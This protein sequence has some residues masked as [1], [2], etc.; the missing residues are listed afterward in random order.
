MPP[1][2]TRT[3]S[4]GETP[5]VPQIHVSPGEE[6]SG[7]GP[8]S[9]QGLRPR[10]RT[11]RNA[12]RPPSNSHGDWPFLRRP[13]SVPEVPV[14]KNSRRSRRISRGGVLHRK[15]ERN[16][17]VVPPFQEPPDV[18]VH[19]R[20][21]CFP[22]TALTFKPRIDSHHVC[23]ERIAG[24][25]RRISGGGALHR[26]GEKKSRVVRPFQESPRCVS[27]FKR[28]LFSLHCLDVQAEDRLP[29]RVHVGQPCGNASWES[30]VGK[31]RGKTIDP[32]LHAADCVTLLLPLW[33]KAHSIR[34]LTPLGRLQKYPKIHVSTGEESS[35]SGPESTQ[36]LR[37][38][39]RRE[40]NPERPPRNSHGDWPF[41][42]PPDRVPDVPVVSR[43]HLPQL[44]KIQEVLPSRR[45]EDHFR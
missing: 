41:L 45:D 35:G 6:S 21:T 7:S 4:P 23:T 32:L 43:E 19:S 12:E 37:P 16:S 5:E 22:C 18:S 8:D 36:G 14:G 11:E 2:E 39:H 17:R 38:R 27:P 31:T 44:E 29:Q 25:S 1:C 34:G 15:G 13:E 10:H 9:T 40:R 30:L 42:R 33:R 24:R 26:K 20:G 3:Y 28:N